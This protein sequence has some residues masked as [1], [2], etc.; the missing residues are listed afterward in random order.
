M[1]QDGECVVDNEVLDIVLKIRPFLNL[2]RKG[3]LQFLFMAL[4]DLWLYE[5][6]K[7]NYTGQ[8]KVVFSTIKFI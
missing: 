1:N 4:D 3:S 6:H 5:Y 7:P 2:I 8:V